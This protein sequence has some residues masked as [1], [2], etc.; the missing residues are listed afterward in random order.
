MGILRLIFPILLGFLSTSGLALALPSASPSAAP[1]RSAWLNELVILNQ[2]QNPTSSPPIPF[3]HPT[4]ADLAKIYQEEINALTQKAK[5]KFGVSQSKQPELRPKIN[6]F[7]HQALSSENDSMLKRLLTEPPQSKGP[8]PDHRAIAEKVLLQLRAHPTA[9]LDA[10]VQ[11]DASG[12]IGFCFGR[13]LLA[14]YRLLKAGISQ[15]DLAKIFLFG[16]LM[17]DR[18]LWRFHV[19]VMA[20]DGKD[21]FIVVD[22]LFDRVLPL[23][24]WVSKTSAFDVK[25]KFSRARFYITDPRKFL[26]GFG[27]YNLDQLE[28]PNLKKYFDDMARNL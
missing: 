4:E 22:P 5:I 15:A 3:S 8:A 18:Q 9:N 27:Q 25:G 20:R 10:T 12:Q 11:Y 19:A 13:A 7:F 17:V 16:E 1:N 2:Q 23:R 26:P 21:G 14:H 24:D 28:D 6:E